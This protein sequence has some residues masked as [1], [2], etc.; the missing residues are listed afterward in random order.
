[1]LINTKVARDTK[2]LVRN[3]AELKKRFP[4]VVDKI[5][6]SVDQLSVAALEN[7]LRLNDLH[8]SNQTVPKND[9][10]VVDIYG[11]AE[12]SSAQV[13]VKRITPS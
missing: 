7:F 4:I 2:E 11:K 3:V 6:D 10:A 5:L 1:M 8:E 12:V 13:H 9:A